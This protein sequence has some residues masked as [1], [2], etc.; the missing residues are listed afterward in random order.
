MLDFLSPAAIDGL[1]LT[2]WHVT[3]AA[4][5]TT[6]MLFVYTLGLRA[7]TVVERRRV[8]RVTDT[9]REIFAAAIVNIRSQPL[10]RVRRREWG[11]VLRNWNMF[12]ALVTGESAAHLIRVGEQ[13]GLVESAKRMLDSNRLTAQLLGA[14]AL[15]Y[16]GDDIRWG[17]LVQLLE[18]SNT[19]L[20]VTAALAL[21]RIDADRAC[22]PVLSAVVQRRDWPRT[23]VSA[24]LKLLGEARISEPLTAAV[25]EG[26]TSTRV[27]L[28]TFAQFIAA[29]LADALAVDMLA[30]S[31]DPRILAASLKL[32]SGR[33]GMPRLALLARHD[34]PF[35]RIEAAKAM[36][37]LGQQEHVDSLERMLTDRHWWVRY[38]A[39]QAIVSLPFVGP[40]SLRQIAVTHRDPF[41][42]DIMTQALA[43]AG[44]A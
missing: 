37:R 16:L 42:R 1:A 21:A 15:G 3:L 4:G 2:A 18:D 13:I 10:P 43:E 39:A 41:A 35:V 44:L 27:H 36:G 11:E 9:W 24:T 34:V 20:S 14:Q 28:M 5:G 17:D 29:D 31:Q 7:A 38:R 25:R 12:R 19:A 6:F 8:A 22:D 40:N 30:E 32:V 26:D 33:L 23:S